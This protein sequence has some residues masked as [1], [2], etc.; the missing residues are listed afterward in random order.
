MMLILLLRGFPLYSK[1]MPKL[2]YRFAST[3]A[4]PPSKSSDACRQMHTIVTNGFAATL[5]TS[6]TSTSLSTRQRRLEPGKVCPPALVQVLHLLFR[7]KVRRQLDRGE[8]CP[9]ALVQVFHFLLRKKVR[10]QFEPGKVCPPALVQLFH[11]L[12]RKKVRRQLDRGDVC[13]P[14]RGQVFHFRLRRKIR[15]LKGAL[16]LGG[17]L[18]DGH[19]RVSAVRAVV[20]D[21]LQKHKHGDSFVETTKQTRLVFLV[22][23]FE[24]H[25]DGVILFTGRR[26]HSPVAIQSETRPKFL[27]KF[28]LR[29]RVQ[30]TEGTRYKPVCCYKMG[31]FF[32]FLL[33]SKSFCLASAKYLRYAS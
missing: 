31:R 30:W 26:W 18:D 23:A 28:L 16:D 32:T 2:S 9:P 12:F 13:I 4:N 29:R 27:D 6:A 24:L 17:R 19:T 21:V 7:K 22:P 33:D 11:L 8:V 1:R 5:S 25:L 10:R 3:N 20:P 15:K 14:L